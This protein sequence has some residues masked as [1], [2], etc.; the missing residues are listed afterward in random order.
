MGENVQ[1][2]FEWCGGK[3][4]KTNG[5]WI[6][7]EIFTHPEWNG[8]KLAI[9]LMDTQGIFDNESSIKDCTSIFGI[10]M[11][12]SSVHCFNVMRN[13]EEDKL[14]FLELCMSYARMAMND[15]HNTALQKLMF[16]VRDWQNAKERPFGCSNEFVNDLLSENSGQTPKMRELRKQARKSIEDIKA[17]LLPH[18][19]KR[20]SQDKSFTGDLI[21]INPQFIKQMQTLIPSIFAPDKLTVKRICGEKIRVSQFIILLKKYVNLFE[22]DRL[23]EPK[24]ILMVSQ[25]IMTTFTLAVNFNI[26]FFINFRCFLFYFKGYRS[27]YPQSITF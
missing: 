12:L 24:T 11:L 4:P 10:S 2:G 13:V 7:S 20:V 23:P 3:N 22:S 17:F 27:N 6:W 5:I 9:I 19:G 26:I 16:I 8:D 21:Q 25:M 18:P 14:Q 1:Q 15:S